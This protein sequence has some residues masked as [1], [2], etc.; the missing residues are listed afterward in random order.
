MNSHIWSFSLMDCITPHQ[1]MPKWE[2]YKL[3]THAGTSNSP[4]LLTDSKLYK[5]TESL[6]KRN[7]YSL[8]PPGSNRLHPGMCWS[9]QCTSCAPPL[10]PGQG[11]LWGRPSV[12]HVG[13]LAA[14]HDSRSYCE[15]LAFSVRSEYPCLHV[16]LP[17][18]QWLPLLSS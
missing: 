10:C 14:L 16:S 18:A 15:S 2:S 13:S 1:K 12:N 6:Y 7:F 4:G 9:K 11:S 8:Y 17:S 3:F 5:D